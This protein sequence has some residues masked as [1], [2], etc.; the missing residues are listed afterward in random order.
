MLSTGDTFTNG[1]YP[2]IDFANGGNIKGMIAAAKTY[3]RASNDKTKSSPAKQPLGDKAKVV[4]YR[5][6]L[7]TA[8]DRMLKLIK[9]GK[10]EDDVIAA[11]PASPISTPSS[12]QA[13]GPRLNQRRLRLAEEA[14]AS[15]LDYFTLSSSTSNISVAFGG[16]APPA[17][18]AP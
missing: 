11:K 1:R 14:V 4:E 13:G 8:R 7:I 10:S 5:A 6:M 2:N 16:M 12:A 9:E 15:G 3:L 18:R 17:P